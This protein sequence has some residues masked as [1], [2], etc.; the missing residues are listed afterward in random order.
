M[1]KPR[2]YL[3]SF[4]DVVNN[5]RNKKYAK[6]QN[7]NIFVLLLWN[8]SNCFL[9]Y[10][11]KNVTWHS[12]STLHSHYPNRRRRKKKKK[13]NC[14]NNQVNCMHILNNYRSNDTEHILV[15]FTNRK[16][17]REGKLTAIP[18][19][20]LNSIICSDLNTILIGRTKNNGRISQLM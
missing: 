10:A 5:R 4:N 9:Q 19:I 3:Y 1:S 14:A 12:C 16:K 13:K 11:K 17:R 8:I 7:N 2:V 6:M 20:I 18:P 15:M